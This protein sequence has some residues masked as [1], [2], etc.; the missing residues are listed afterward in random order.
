MLRIIVN[1]Y[2]CCPN[3][4]SEPGMGWNWIINLAKY[5]EV[6]VISEGEF[7][8]QI[9]AWMAEQDART[10]EAMKIDAVE[11]SGWYS[12]NKYDCQGRL[13]FYWNPVSPEVRKMCWNQGDWRFYRYYEKW[14]RKTADIARRIVSIDKIDILHQLNMIG[15]R[16][17]GYLWQVSKETDIPFV[18]GPVDAKG[19]FPMAYTE[20]APIKN[21]LFLRIKNL[22]TEFQLRYEGRVHKA[23]KQASLILGANSNSV[24]NFNAYFNKDCVLMNETG[25]NIH[26]L[27]ENSETNKDIRHIEETES[28]TYE[29][30]CHE[31]SLLWVGKFDFRKQLSLAIR[32]IEK[33]K[34]L[35]VSLHI[36]GDGDV[37][38]L[39]KQIANFEIED[40]IILH[41]LMSH[42]KVQN[43]MQKSDA[44]FF[45][46]VAEGTPHVVLEAVAN[47]LPIVCFDTC[48]QGDVVSE[49]IGIKIPLSIPSQ[50]IKDFAEKIEFLYNHPEE[51]QRMSEN[52]KKR[53]EELSWDNKA[54]QLVKLYESVI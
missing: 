43:I 15:F 4:G 32:V 7:R 50:S 27:C 45:T 44:L 23:V 25:C 29:E 54:K 48:G 34:H 35:N 9:E 2:T 51:L 20:G 11:S 39:K 31:L 8:P 46:S 6:Y 19:S 36:V 10:T 21:I 26:L 33:I 30:S 41:G 53:A 14:Q 13:C 1:S 38:S 3:M 5:C 16:E 40:K 42:S 17:P 12:L 47:G 49:D 37:L 22:I 18:W 24:R 28:K 52:C